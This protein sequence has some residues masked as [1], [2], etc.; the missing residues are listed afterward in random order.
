MRS[1]ESVEM[2]TAMRRAAEPAAARRPVMCALAHFAAIIAASRR[3]TA[4]TRRPQVVA[5]YR[6]NSLLALIEK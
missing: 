4:K 5:D 2:E 3:R 1:H 6:E